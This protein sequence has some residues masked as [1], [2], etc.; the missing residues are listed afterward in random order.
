[1]SANELNRAE[2]AD[3]DDDDTWASQALCILLLALT[4]GPNW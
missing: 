2:F 4:L 3:D 1:M